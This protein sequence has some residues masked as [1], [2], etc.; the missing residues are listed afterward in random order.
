ML[1]EEGE[2]REREVQKEKEFD[3]PAIVVYQRKE[4]W[5]RSFS[6]QN[7]GL[8]MVELWGGSQIGSI[9]LSGSK[10]QGKTPLRTDR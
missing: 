9:Q 4:I 8:G 1:L 3:M 5:T 2:K 6:T 7:L 10:S